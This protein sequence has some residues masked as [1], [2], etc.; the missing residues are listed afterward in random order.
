LVS[1]LALHVG[2]IV[3]RLPVTLIGVG[4]A[5]LLTAAPV[6]LSLILLAALALPPALILLAALILTLLSTLVGIL[7]AIWHISSPADR[8]AATVELPPG[9]AM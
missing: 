1:L 5:G 6:A 4:A 2:A 9:E 7:G 3:V 8:T